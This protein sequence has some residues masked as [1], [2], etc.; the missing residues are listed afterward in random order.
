MGWRD[1]ARCFESYDPRF[2]STDRETV[3]Q[4]ADDYCRMC[5]VFDECGDHAEPIGVWAGRSRHHDPQ[6]RNLARQVLGGYFR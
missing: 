6:N 4:V 5:P 2:F 1:E 3:K